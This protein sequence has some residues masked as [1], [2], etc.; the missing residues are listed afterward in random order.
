MDEHSQ[1][2]LITKKEESIIAHL[3]DNLL[4]FGERKTK[5]DE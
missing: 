3:W 2:K 4:I 5:L 1:S